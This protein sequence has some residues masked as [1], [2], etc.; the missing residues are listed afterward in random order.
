[1]VDQM[2]YFV[3]TVFGKKVLTLPRNA[4]ELHREM[5]QQICFWGLFQAEN[6]KIVL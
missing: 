3:G 1:M 6:A 4:S 2:Q 5:V